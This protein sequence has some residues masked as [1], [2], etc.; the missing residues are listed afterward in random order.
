MSQRDDLNAGKPRRKFGWKGSV[1][2]LA[3]LAAGALLGYATGRMT[4]D[5]ATGLRSILDALSPWD[6]LALPFLMLAV[7]AVHEAGHL[8][9]GLRQGMRFLLYVVGPFGF[10]GGG[11]GIRFRWFF[12]LGTLGGLAA[13]MP[14]PQR[15]LAMQM[16]PMVLGGPLASLLLAAAGFAVMAMSEG[17]LAAYALIVGLLSAAVFVLTALPFRAGGFMSDGMQWLAYR[18][19][20]AGMERRARLTAL[21]GMSMAGTRPRDL[22]EETLRLTLEAADGS[23]VLTDMGAWFY[24][25]A[26]DLDRGEV[27]AADAWLAKMADALGAYPDGFR[28]SI[29]IELAMHA[30]LHRRDQV[31][32]LRWLRSARGGIVDAS[33]RH[34]AEAATAVLLGD[35][36]TAERSL[37]EADQRLKQSMDP[38]FALLSRDQIDALR[39]T[40][41]ASS[42]AAGG[43]SLR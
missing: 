42:T 35:D 21:M 43:P 5:S 23:E 14:D 1:A 29:A 36:A 6:L 9:M 8:L 28:Q 27:A 31:E 22:D 10:V 13:A 24:A 7:I 4:A 12:N 25:Y 19:G 32:A 2:L 11:E 40:L 38:G 17:R 26:R 34:L 30:A 15:P 16:K 41:A 3:M 18:R 39:R 37:V 33:R 20:G